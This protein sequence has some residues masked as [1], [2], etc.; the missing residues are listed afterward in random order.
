MLIAVFVLA[1]ALMSV[2]FATILVTRNVG[3]E[4]DNE[5]AR[6]LALQIM[7]E[8]EEVLFVPSKS[9]PWDENAYKQNII[10]VGQ[11]D[12]N[13]VFKASAKVVSVG[14]IPAK[15]PGHPPVSADIL[16]TV[17][18]RTAAKNSNRMTLEREVSVSGWQNVGDKS[19]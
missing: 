12:I 14:A 2:M 16:V 6:Q 7:E 10:N 18:W 3:A 4:K 11:R 1:V 13:G 9:A 8:C 17:E 15:L 5:R 19:L